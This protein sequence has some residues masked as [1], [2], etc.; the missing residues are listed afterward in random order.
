[1]NPRN[2]QRDPTI[3]I[4]EMAA[5]SEPVKAKGRDPVANAKTAPMV[6]P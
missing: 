6:P 2:S 1:L 3:T 4:D 5:L